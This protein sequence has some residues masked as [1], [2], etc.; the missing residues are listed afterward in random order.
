MPQKPILRRSDYEVLNWLLADEILAS[1]AGSRERKTLRQRLQISTI[2]DDARLPP[3]V[4]AM[5]SMVLASDTFSDELE[6]FEL[7]Y[8]QEANIAFGKLSVFAPLGAAIIGRQVGESI[9][10][11]VPSGQ[12]N[13]RLNRVQNRSLVTGIDTLMSRP[14]VAVSD[15]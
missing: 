8:P 12:L 14:I 5:H 9:R 10:V 4:V 13:V 3:P 7:V 15:R 2:V 6:E 11:P 1:I